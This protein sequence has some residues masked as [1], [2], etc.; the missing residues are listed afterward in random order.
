VLEGRLVYDGQPVHVRENAIQLELWQDGYTL[1]TAIPVYVKQDGSFQATLFDGDY[2]L[3]RK[4]NVG[5][6]VNDPDT[7]LVQLRGGQTLDVPV[8]PFFVIEDAQ[9]TRTGGG[10]TATFTVK[11]L[12]EDRE[13]E[14]VGLYVGST[15]FVDPNYNLVAVERSAA[16]IADP[17]APITLSADVSAASAG[18]DYVYVR[19]AA[20]T[21]GAAEMIYTEVQKVELN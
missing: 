10:V 7:I 16:E 13:L 20:K 12:V 3:V 1:H 4:Q 21:V 5:P 8:Q 11:R 18:Q 9:V 2:K 6:W 17:G 15:R 19:V 14:K